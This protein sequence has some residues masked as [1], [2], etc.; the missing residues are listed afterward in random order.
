MALSASLR[1]AWPGW[2]HLPRD[3]RDTLF[4]LAVI[5]WTV[6]PHLAHLPPWC[7]ALTALMLERPK[8]PAIRML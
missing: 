4:Q 7:M 5:G 2:R 6:L 3:S 1:A 8:R